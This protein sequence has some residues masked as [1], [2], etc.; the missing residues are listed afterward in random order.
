LP[1]LRNDT[2]PLQFEPE[3]QEDLMFLNDSLSGAVNKRDKT[4]TSAP[5]PRSW[6]WPASAVAEGS[7]KFILCKRALCP[8]LLMM[9]VVPL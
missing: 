7:P 2:A 5:K 4:T 3:M 1:G 9:D 8:K 6:R